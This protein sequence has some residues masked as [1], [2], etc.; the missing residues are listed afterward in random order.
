VKL[1]RIIKMY[2]N[3]TYSKVPI[4]KNLSDAFAIQNDVKQ[5]D[6]LYDHFQLCFR[7]CN[8]EGPRKSGRLEL[9]GTHQLLVY[10]DDVNVLGKNTNA[11]RKNT[12]ALM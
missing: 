4:G 9:I 11:I 12:E 8:Q 6:N 10:A 1:V 5:G 2:L 3:K 7:I